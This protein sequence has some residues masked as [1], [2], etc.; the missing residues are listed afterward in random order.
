MFLDFCIPFLI[1]KLPWAW[2]LIDLRYYYNIC[3]LS[4]SWL[5]RTKQ[6]SVLRM[7]SFASIKHQEFRPCSALGLL[8]PRFS[9]KGFLCL[10]DVKIWTPGALTINC[11]RRSW[12]LHFVPQNPML[13]L[14]Q[15]GDLHV[16]MSI[17][18]CGS[19]FFFERIILFLALWVFYL[20][21]AKIE[22]KKE[23]N[24]KAIFL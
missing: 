23:Q 10:L 19:L 9:C 17:S 11:S 15:N 3:T 21:L 24:L 5:W 2:K 8:I 12:E 4:N 6:S 18:S 16:N 1:C 14:S 13:Q 20:A 22:K 7:T